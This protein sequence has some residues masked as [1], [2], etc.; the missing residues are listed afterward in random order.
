MSV[1]DFEEA[2]AREQTAPDD[3]AERSQSSAGSS[4]T[5]ASASFSSSSTTISINTI[6]ENSV[7]EEAENE[8]QVL[9]AEKAFTNHQNKLSNAC[10][11]SS[12]LGLSYPTPASA[13]AE[14]IFSATSVPALVHLLQRPKNDKIP[15]GDVYRGYMYNFS[16]ILNF[17]LH[18]AGK[19]AVEFRQHECCIDAEAVGRWVRFV[20]RVVRKAEALAEK[21]EPINCMS[22]IQEVED[23]CGWIGLDVDDI[24]YW[25]ERRDRFGKMKEEV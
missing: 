15:Q 4:F 8:A 23:L 3:A 2:W 9:A 16:N 24:G 17:Y 25:V 21:D 7:S 14:A 13:M 6:T 1:E 5:H 18:G 22:S 20:E 11:L 19:P 12:L 10:Y